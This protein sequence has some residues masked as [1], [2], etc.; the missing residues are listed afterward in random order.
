METAVRVLIGTGTTRR[1]RALNADTQDL[2][3]SP[4]AAT[5]RRE[6]RRSQGQVGLLL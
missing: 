5:S 4:E 1:Q 3:V 6:D 2:Y